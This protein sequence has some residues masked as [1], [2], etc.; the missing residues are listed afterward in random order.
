M[1]THAL[2]MVTGSSSVWRWRS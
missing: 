1:K 2:M